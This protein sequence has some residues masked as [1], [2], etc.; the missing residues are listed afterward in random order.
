MLLV[1]VRYL[2]LV[3]VP[4]LNTDIGIGAI[5]DIVISTDTDISLSNDSW[6]WF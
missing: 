4:T 3:S 1:L 6:N 2:I 5:P